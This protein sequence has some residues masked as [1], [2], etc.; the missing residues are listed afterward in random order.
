[1]DPKRSAQ[2]KLQSNLLA[3]VKEF[4]TLPT[5]YSQLS[6]TIA[7]P[8]CSA[9]DV[10]YIISRDQSSATKVLQV[11]NSAVFGFVRQIKSINQAVVYVGFEEIKSIVL[12][13]SVIEL[14]QDVKKIDS[15]DPQE[16]WQY[17]FFTGVIARNIAKQ[18]GEK[19]VEEYFVA[20]I[21]HTIGR[22]LLLISIPEIFDKILKTAKAKKLSVSKLERSVIGVSSSYLSEM[23][24]EK[25]KLPVDLAKCLGNYLSG[26][27]DGRYHKL[28]SV[29]HLA[30]VSTSMF[31]IGNNGDYT[32][33]KLNKEIWE[34][35]KLPKNFFSSNYLMIM[36]EYNDIARLLLSDV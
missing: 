28:K 8:R 19:N 7:N 25:W 23:L 33:P 27:K 21:I 18:I 35:L 10:A 9:Q 30:T 26:M 29:V 34:Y 14:F 12:A 16:L 15:L 5:V 2:Q 6:D 20:G 1:M 17:S 24:A 3:K 32:I 11:S 36:K 22:L 31:D 13:I 4:P